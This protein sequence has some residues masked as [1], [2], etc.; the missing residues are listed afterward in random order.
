MQKRKKNFLK[1][2]SKSIGKPKDLWKAIKSLGLPSKSGRCIVGA[3][4][5]NQIVKHDTKSILKTFKS[6][7]SNLTGN[8]LAKHRKSPNRYTIKFISDYYK[9]LSLS[10]NFKLDATTEGYL[11][12][13]L[14]NVEVTKAA[15]IDQI[16]GKFLK[17]GARILAKPISELCNLSMTLGSFPDACKIAKVKPLFK[18]GSKTDPSN[19]RPISL[20][21]L[22]SKVF[23]RVVFNQTEEFLS[24]NKVLYDYQSGFRKNH[25]TDTCLSFLN[26]KILK[27]FDDGLLTGMILINLQKAFDTIN[28]DILLKK[29]SIIGFSD[30]TVK[31]FQSYLSN[32]K[33]TVNL[34]N[35]FS[36]VSNISCGVP[37]GSIVGPLLFLIYVNDMPMAVKC[38]LFLYADDTCLVFQ[39]KNVKDIE[40]QLNEDFA[41]ICDWFVDNKLSIHFGEDKTKSILFASKSKIKKLQKLEIIYNSIPIKQHSRV[42]YLGCILEE[43][44]SGESMAHKVISKVNARLKFLHRKNKYLTPNLRRL[45]CNALIQPHFDYACSAWYPNLSKKLKNRIQ[46]SQNK[47]I[48]FCLQLDKMS[49]ISQKEFKAINWLK[50]RYNQC[51][52]SI[53]FTYFDNQC[54]HYLTEVFMK[55]L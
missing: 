4:T 30:H 36:E 46:T 51:V 31:W 34:E 23:E 20:L 7:Y 14:K 1:T 21:P 18:K 52:N 50:E 49:H 11:F 22:L 40:K 32:R 48:R 27:G 47:C 28:H 53:V 37:Q 45:L 41:Q 35:S 3:L 2:N 26:D 55:A 39:S 5:E 6:F 24:L 29:L 17:D 8:L 43:T 54:P 25:S 12:N 38:N 19:Y 42:T 44:M 13:I 33:F 10:E 9:K 16:S 15:G